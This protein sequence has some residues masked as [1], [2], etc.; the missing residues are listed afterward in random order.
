MEVPAG[1]GRVGI[2][3]GV[4]R[5]GVDGTGGLVETGA[6]LEAVGKELGA[7]ALRGN[8]PM[9]E[10]AGTGAGR[11]TAGIKAGWAEPT[12][13]RGITE[14]L[15]RGE[16]AGRETGRFGVSRFISVC[17]VRAEPIAGTGL[18]L[19]GKTGAGADVP[20]IC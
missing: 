20:F 10:S 18:G 5:A 4:G 19:P 7:G 11:F 15:G 6:V 8:V 17:M 2:G 3:G 12:D 1:I 14:G 16:T 9:S 13:R